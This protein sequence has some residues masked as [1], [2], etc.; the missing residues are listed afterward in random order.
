[1]SSKKEQTK[2]VNIG[3]KDHLPEAITNIH[4]I[5]L[6]CCS[7]LK[8]LTIKIKPWRTTTYLKLCGSLKMDDA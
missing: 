3:T 6:W 7:V 5:E 2:M 8:C 4:C 1:M